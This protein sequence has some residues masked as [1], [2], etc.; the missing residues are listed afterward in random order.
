MIRSIPVFLLLIINPHFFHAQV[1]LFVSVSGNDRWS[2]TLPAPLAGKQDGPFATL[3]RAQAEIRILN[4]SGRL[5]EGAII[6]VREGRYSLARTLTFGPADS[7]TDSAEIVWKAHETE[8]VTITGAHR[9]SGWRKVTDGR[10]L[11]RLDSLARGNVAQTSLRAQGIADYGVIEQRGSPGLELFY[12]GRRMQ[13]ARWPNVGWLRVADV[14]Q[15]G[16]SLYNVGLEREKRYDGVPVGRHYGRI[17]YEGDRPGRWKQQEDVV[18]HGYWT[19]DWSDSFQRVKSI[20][21]TSHEITL[22][23]PHHH[24]GYTKNQRYYVLNA[25]EE[26]DQPGEWYL[27]RSTGTMYFW[28]PGPLGDHDCSVSVLGEPL[29]VMEKAKHIVVRGFVF[30][31]SRAEGIV[32]RS[33]YSNRIEG[34]TF[35]QLGGEAVGVHGGARNRIQSCDLYDL[36]LGAVRLMGGDRASL[37]P[38]NNE[39]VNNH[40]HHFS[41]WLRTGQYGI[42]LDGVENR[43]AHN[44][45]HDAPFEAIYL[46][47]NE[48]LIEFNEIHDVTQ[49]TGDAGALHTGR[50]WTW[51]GNVIRYNYFHD[52]VGPGLHGVMAVYLDDWA[53]GFTVF[54]NVF[55]RAGR[56]AFI[57]GGRDNTVEN[58][59]FIECSPSV[60]VDARGLGWAGY[61][62]DGTFPWLFDRMEDMKFRQP[63]YSIRYPELLKLYG[64]EP[65]VP[66]GNKI[67]RNI[68]VGG[69]WMDVYDYW[70]FDF[71][72][73]AVKDNLIADPIILRRR[74]EG[75][76]GWDPYYL[77]ID[78]VEGYDMIPIA[79]SARLGEFKDN[80]FTDDP[81]FV[82]ITKRDFRL[83]EDSPAFRMGFER[84]PFERIG[85]YKDEFRKEME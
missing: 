63:P 83:R 16:D 14:P 50:D 68:S 77:N 2:G 43:I 49:E 24:Y 54:G 72:V 65:R 34:C 73:V 12:R 4:A 28:P 27:D 35:R 64:D 47:G 39:A 52:L 48:H 60:H 82:D 71:S 40:I 13:L 25:L 42:F 61:Y 36:S 10:T 17:R 76:S 80:V 15:S 85:L 62:F 33:G 19:W 29:M 9:I 7:G 74:S 20:D 45:I 67:I 3:E 59:I 69:R 46:R 75:Q 5:K 18:L 30:E 78:K 66:K 6:S 23:E 38:G 26:L 56:A 37:I 31:Q 84:I 32:I 22:A 79:Q 57:G 11:G 41:T 58:N 70:E 53:S 8:K 55:F 44:R 1:R 21:P 81:G 51:R